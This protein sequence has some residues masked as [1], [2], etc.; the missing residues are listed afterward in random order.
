MGW[1]LLSRKSCLT[2]L[3]AL[4]P[5]PWSSRLLPRFM[6][7]DRVTRS[8]DHGPPSSC[9]R[10]QIWMFFPVPRTV[11]SVPRGDPLPREVP[12]ARW[13]VRRGLHPTVPHLR[14]ASRVN[15]DALFLQP[16]FKGTVSWHGR[17]EG[18]PQDQCVSGLSSQT[19]VWP[20]LTSLAPLRDTSRP[21]CLW[22]GSSPGVPLLSSLSPEP[23]CFR[24][25]DFS[26]SLLLS[27]IF[28]SL[29]QRD[30][31]ALLPRWRLPSPCLAS[32]GPLPSPCSADCHSSTSFFV[33]LLSAGF[34]RCVTARHCLLLPL[35]LPFS[36]LLFKVFGGRVI[37]D[38][39]CSRV[40]VPYTETL[41]ISDHGS[42]CTFSLICVSSNITSGLWVMGTPTGQ[43]CPEAWIF[44][45]SSAWD[46]LQV[47]LPLI[48]GF[49]IC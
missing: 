16:V 41:R 18:G 12:G 23:V 29:V 13:A 31:S 14:W 3:K 45:P 44:T 30:E 17:W 28:G 35:S 24:Q 21:L 26:S 10:R 40:E 11:G 4:F 5:S 7:H 36:W 27:F 32:H 22:W 42:D 15:Q 38:T 1:E 47:F 48:F 20:A 46:P 25:S 43:G 6:F 34:C 37:I 9:A 33:W 39:T 49:L 2:L 8:K 19:G